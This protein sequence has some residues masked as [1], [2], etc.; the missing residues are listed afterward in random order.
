MNRTCGDEAREAARIIREGG[1]IVYPTETLYGIGCDPWNRAAVERV[2]L[3]KQR[4][5]SRTMLLLA[6]SRGMVE[7]RFGALDKLSS[8]LAEAFWPGLLTLVFRPSAGCPDYLCGP[9]GGVAVRVTA[10]P[11]CA[12]IIGEF[13]GPI[14][15]TSANLMGEPPALSFKDADELFGREADMVLGGPRVRGRT[16]NDK[17]GELMTRTPSTI[18]DTVSGALRCIREG[19]VPFALIREAARR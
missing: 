1:V 14:V 10:H 9:S 8:K 3:M 7:D 2:L 16:R 13:G 6:D 5:Q 15:S 18:V 4:P 19:T 12:E 11:L 17:D